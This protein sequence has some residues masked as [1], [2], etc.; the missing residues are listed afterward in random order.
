MGL[1]TWVYLS[2]IQSR[3]MPY[4]HDE[5]VDMEKRLIGVTSYLVP[6]YR[7]KTTYDVKKGITW[8]ECFDITPTSD[9]KQ[10]LKKWV[11]YWQADGPYL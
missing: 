8:E 3:L 9:E 7:K 4:C 5:W 1:Y 10:V 6:H 2:L 11:E